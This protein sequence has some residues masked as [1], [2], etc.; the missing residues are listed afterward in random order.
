MALAKEAANHIFVSERHFQ[1]ILDKGAVTRQPPKKYDLDVVREEAFKSLRIVAG[2]AS[3]ATGDD[4]AALRHRKF[5]AETEKAEMETALLKAKQVKVADV[6]V[7]WM[8]IAERIRTN[9]LALPSK[10]APLLI[11]AD[12][13][14]EI[15]RIIREQVNEILSE[16]S[17]AN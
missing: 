11:D 3:G 9:F 2:N 15:E 5:T 12:T 6:E 1:T 14:V 10:A 17:G 16:L 4:Y 13:M 8:R 7:E